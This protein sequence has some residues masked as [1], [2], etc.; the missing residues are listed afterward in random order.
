VFHGVAGFFGDNSGF[1]WISRSATGFAILEIYGG[2]GFEVFRISQLVRPS[3][4]EFVTE[5]IGIGG[6]ETVF[7][8]SRDPGL[9]SDGRTD[10]F[11]LALWSV[12]QSFAA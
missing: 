4:T 3:V 8:G 5:R 7:V 1:I 2:G 11:G 10:H 6:I 9:A 12:H